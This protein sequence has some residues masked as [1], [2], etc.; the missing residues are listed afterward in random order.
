MKSMKQKTYTKT[1]IFLYVMAFSFLLVAVI[2]QTE[3]PTVLPIAQTVAKAPTPPKYQE[4]DFPHSER[5]PYRRF[6]IVES[7]QEG[8]IHHV[9]YGYEN[10]KAGNTK[11]YLGLEIICANK[12]MRHAGYG[13]DTPDKARPNESTYPQEW[14]DAFGMYNEKET[15][16]TSDE[17]DIFK[18][19]CGMK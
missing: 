10:L 1:D 2:K 16:Y 14:K 3:S 19:V 17:Q 15:T 11:G 12:T 7:K 18:F 8:S 5:V 6:F 4:I 9:I 13:G